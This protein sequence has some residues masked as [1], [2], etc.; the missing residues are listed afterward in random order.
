MAISTGASPHTLR[1]GLDS[2][3]S[4]H[5]QLALRV[6]LFIVVAHWAEHLVQAYQIYVMG[7]PIPEARGVLGIPFPWLVTSE[8]MHYGYALVMM[9]GLFLLRPGFTGRSGTWWKAS[10]GIQ[11]WH[12]LEHLLLL[13]QVLV[14]ANL[15]GKAAPTS[16]VQLIMPRV[17]L[18]LFYNTLV[19]IPMVVAMYLHTRANRQDNAT[20]RCACAPKG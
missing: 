17:E 18:H 5:H 1:G 4:G 9:V 16:L 19:T 11:V 15:L 14:G 3:N 2:L 20:A 6:Y 8:W 7:W 12:H 13:V 10:L